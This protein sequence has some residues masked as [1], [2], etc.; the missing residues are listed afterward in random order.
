LIDDG[1]TDGSGAVCDEYAARFPDRIRLIRQNNQGLSGARNTGLDH[2]RGEL[3]AFLD[4]DDAFHPDMIRRMVRALNRSRA[5]I[6]VCGYGTYQTQKEM[7]ASK[8]IRVYTVPS[9]RLLS[10]AEAL[11]CMIDGTISHAVWNRLYRRKCWEHLRFPQG[12]VYEDM[13]TSCRVLSEA[14]RILLIP[15]VLVKYRKR[16][17]SITHTN[18]L[19]NTRDYFAAVHQYEG[20]VRD[21]VPAFYRQDQLE[22]LQKNLLRGMIVFWTKLP[23]ACQK[24]AAQL[25]REI[26]SAGSRVPLSPRYFR[27]W[28]G[29][30]MIRFCPWLIPVI[31]PVYRPLRELFR[32][33]T[34]R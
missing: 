33:V 17:G 25:R 10:R 8:R 7:R 6:V 22:A 4:P 29:F 30:Q 12:K 14:D 20:F 21:H 26:L 15:E 18:S 24:E 27:T 11:S 5:D 28:A 31:M 23:A 34:G 32:K 13:A 1:S 2:M 16:P 3:V 9:A 19:R